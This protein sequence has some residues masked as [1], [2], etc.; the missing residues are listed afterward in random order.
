M[1]FNLVLNIG[2]RLNGQLMGAGM[3][4]GNS[5]LPMNRGGYD[6]SILTSECETNSM[7]DTTDDDAATTR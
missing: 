3:R 2:Q 6:S 5:G 7:L 4:G 1:F